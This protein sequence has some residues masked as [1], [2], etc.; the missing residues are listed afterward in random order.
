MRSAYV[1]DRSSSSGARSCGEPAADQVG[2][3]G[4]VLVRLCGARRP[5]S[6]A[7]AFPPP[8]AH[9]PLDGAAGHVM[10]LAAQPQPHLA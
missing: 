7:G 9:D 6:P 1:P 5:A 10:A 4:G 8:L 2:G 3:T